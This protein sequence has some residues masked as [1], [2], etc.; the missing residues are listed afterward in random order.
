VSH[1]IA[2]LKKSHV[3]KEL[4][5]CGAYEVISTIGKEKND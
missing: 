3:I 2:K 1:S 4:I 5:E